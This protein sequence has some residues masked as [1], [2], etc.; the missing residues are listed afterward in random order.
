M[1]DIKDNHTVNYILTFALS[2]PMK[3]LL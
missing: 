1:R 2:V 3:K